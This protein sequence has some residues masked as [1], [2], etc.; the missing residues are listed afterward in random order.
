LQLEDTILELARLK[1]SRR[2]STVML[3]VALTLFVLEQVILQPIIED[4]ISIPYLDLVILV[5]LFFGAKFVEGGL[6][7]YF[8]KQERKKIMKK[9]E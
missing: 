6:E 7:E 3:I 8:L 5:I 4:S 2:A 1:I 9:K